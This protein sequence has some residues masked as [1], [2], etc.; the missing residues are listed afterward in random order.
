MFHGKL[1]KDTAK[2]LS[3]LRERIAEAKIPS[4]KIDESLNIATWNIRD[5]GKKTRLKASIHYI[6]EILWQFDLVAL[7]ELGANLTDMRRVM[8][9]LGPHWRIVYS[10]FVG[11]AGGNRERIGF[12]YDKRAATFTGLAAEADAPRKKDR[13][14]KEYVPKYGWWRSPYM[15]S[16]RA[17]NFDFVLIGAHMRWGSGARAREKPIGLFADWVHKRSRSKDAVDKDIIVMGDFNIPRRNHFLYDAITRKGL[18]IPSALLGIKGTNLE[19]KKQYDQ[20][21]HYPFFT[22]CFTKKGGVVD[23]YAGNMKP[24]FPGSGLSDQKLTYQLSDHLPLWLHI[25]TDV[26]DE[27]LDQV[28]NRARFKAQVESGRRAVRR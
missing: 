22:K 10:D 13:K 21:L 1:D 6:A 19:Q 4:S 11:D 3:I 26:A 27:E 28:L 14:T 24:L 12:L 2:G 5:F 7:I 23:F 16:F 18:R 25:D 20:I 15:A 9:I 17:G 8:E